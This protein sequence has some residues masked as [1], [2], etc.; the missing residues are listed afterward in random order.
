[1]TCEAL[2]LPILSRFHLE[3]LGEEE[4]SAYLPPHLGCLWNLARSSA[5][6]RL[7]LVLS[8]LSG[9]PHAAYSLRVAVG[10]APLL[11]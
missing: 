1:M 7:L 5:C 11:R 8:G 9:R 3:S 4:K 2:D 6:L 10:G